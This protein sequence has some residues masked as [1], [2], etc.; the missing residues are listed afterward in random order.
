MIYCENCDWLG[1]EDETIEYPKNKGVFRCPD[2]GSANTV[3]YEGH[4]VIDV[5]VVPDE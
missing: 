1:N 4:A 5:K 3:E 2:C